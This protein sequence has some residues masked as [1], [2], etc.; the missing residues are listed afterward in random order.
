MPSPSQRSPSGFRTKGLTWRGAREFWDRRV[1]GGAA[2]VAA[3]CAPEHRRLL[4]DAVLASAWYDALPIVPIAAV[5]AEL[6]GVPLAEL[7]RENAVY[8]ARRDVTGVHRFLLSLVSPETVAVR[9]GKVSLQYFDFGTEES[10]RISA[11][12]VQTA[13]RGI[14]EPLADWLGW[15]I[16]GFVPIALEHAGARD[17]V[18]TETSRARDGVRDGVPLVAIEIRIAWTPR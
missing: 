17:V 12:V 15:C 8:V 2:A 16:E 3:G 11:G 10:R 5:A 1:P 18:V 13:R 7:V 4:E 6:A 14:P 9:L